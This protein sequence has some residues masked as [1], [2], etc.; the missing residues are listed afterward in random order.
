MI[1]QR[2]KSPCCGSVLYVFASG[3]SKTPGVSGPYVMCTECRTEYLINYKTGNLLVW[4]K[5]DKGIVPVAMMATAKLSDETTITNVLPNE[6]PW[7]T[8]VEPHVTFWKREFPSDSHS[9]VT[10]AK[11][12]TVKLLQK[13]VLESY[14]RDEPVGEALYDAGF[15]LKSE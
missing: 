15:R 12:A 2:D 5:N 6:L 3:G 14:Y 1:N 4:I 8:S 7:D 9:K 13:V 10:S 11:D